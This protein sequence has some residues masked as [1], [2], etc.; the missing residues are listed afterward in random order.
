[1]CFVVKKIIMKNKLQDFLSTAKTKIEGEQYAGALQSLESALECNPDARL[2]IEIYFQTAFCKCGLEEYAEAAEYLETALSFAGNMPYSEKKHIYDL[3]RMVYAHK[4]D[5]VKLAELCRTLIRIEEDKAGLMSNLLDATAQ[6]DTWSEIAR[7]FDEFT[8]IALNT[9]ALL[10]KIRC[11][12]NLGR[13][14]EAFEVSREYIERFGE[15]HHLCTDLM[16]LSFRVGDSKSGGDYYNKAIA[17]CDDPAWRLWIGGMFLTN[18]AY[19]GMVS[20][21]EYP[22]LVG[23]MR[24]STEKLLVNTVFNNVPKPF[25]KLKLGYLSEDFKAH[26]VGY[27]LSPV[28]SNTISSHCHNFCFNLAQPKDEKDLVTEQFK[29]LADRFEEVFE[30]PDSYIE[31]LFSA[32]RIDIAFDMMCHSGGNRILLFARRLAPVQISWIGFPVTSGVAAMD[33]VIVD[34]NTDPPGSEKYYTEKLLYIPESFLCHTLTSGIDAAPPAFTRNGYITFAC[35]H[36]LKKVT[37]KTLYMWRLVLEKCGNSRLKIMGRMPEENDELREKFNERFK[38]IGMPMERVSISPS[39]AMKDYFAA[40]NDVDIMLDTYPFSG[41]TTT[42]DALRMGRPI[43]TLV[44]ERHV[45]RVSY[46]LLKHVGLDDLAA[47]SEDEYVEKAVALA[48]DHERLLG[49]NADLPRRVDESP[50]TDQSAF[51]RN[52]E[53]II[54]DVWVRYCF[55]NRNGYYD[56][57]ADNPPELLEQVV[58]ATIYIERKLDAGEDVE[59]ALAAEYHRAQKAFFNKLHLVTNDEGFVREYDKLVRMIGRRLD[60]NDLRLAISAA[61][62][63]LNVFCNGEL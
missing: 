9:K 15:D 1:M 7:V 46:S 3:L 34:K 18:D 58:N 36:N 8:D 50:L 45:T 29:S 16:E 40:Y 55:E 30:Q 5:Y 33:Y 35:F 63:Y 2:A 14:K 13:Y 41:A 4:P 19:Q 38:K 53:K 39:C 49:I 37:D 61:K 23:N 32:N 62:R 44:G 12:T 42:F 28:M 26:P 52:F 60:E 20:D 43:I 59:S 25:R 11:F 48:N 27:F 22:E 17:L 10:R 24:R 51:R 47:F 57:D 6:L 56:Y 21:G 54:R 31:Q